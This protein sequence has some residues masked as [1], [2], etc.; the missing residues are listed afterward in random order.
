MWPRF[1]WID[2]F[3][4]VERFVATGEQQFEAM[5]PFDDYDEDFPSAYRSFCGFHNT[6]WSNS[7]TPCRKHNLSLGRMLTGRSSMCV[8][9]NL[10]ISAT[11]HSE[12]REGEERDGGLGDAIPADI[13]KL[14]LN[15]VEHEMRN[16]GR[17]GF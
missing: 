5:G 12:Y 6:S 14:L 3:E 17:F 16:G 4:S 7:W 8:M 11:N 2:S 1:V 9:G 13:P 15:L 10:L